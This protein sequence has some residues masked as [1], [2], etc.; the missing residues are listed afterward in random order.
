MSM[1]LF[2]S[3]KAFLFLI[4]IFHVSGSFR[5]FRVMERHQTQFFHERWLPSSIMKKLVPNIA[6][7]SMRGAEDPPS[8]DNNTG[9]LR[10]P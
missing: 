7:L 10:I 4:Y 9:A 3:R 8:W 1:V 6:Q 2:F 5:I